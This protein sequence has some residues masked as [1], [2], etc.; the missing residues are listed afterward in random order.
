MAKVLV[1]NIDVK[2]SVFFQVTMDVFL[3]TLGRLEAAQITELRVISTTNYSS[4]WAVNGL[5]IKTR[6]ELH[7]PVTCTDKNQF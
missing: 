1:S 6:F 7:T 4:Q 2:S 5:Q 3:V